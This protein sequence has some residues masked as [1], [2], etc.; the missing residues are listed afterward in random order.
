MPGAAVVGESRAQSRSADSSTHPTS[1]RAKKSAHGSASPSTAG[2]DLAP[3]ARIGI[4]HTFREDAGQGDK[5]SDSAH[6][7]PLSGN[8][9][10]RAD[11]EAAWWI[12]DDQS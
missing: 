5:G 12:A 9:S 6:F 2:A 10:S 4:W 1:S 3:F 11:S 8:C 7:H